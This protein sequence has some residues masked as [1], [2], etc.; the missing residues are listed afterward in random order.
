MIKKENGHKHVGIAEVINLPAK[1]KA[2]KRLFAFGLAAA[3]RDINLIHASLDKK[4]VV[5]QKLEE[6]F[7]SHKF[8]EARR[9]I[10]L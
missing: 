4:K 8:V 10:S 7:E 3:K 6:V 1:P 5:R 9:I 2:N